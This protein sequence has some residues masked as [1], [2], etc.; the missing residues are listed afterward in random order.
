MFRLDDKAILVAGGA[1]YLGTPLCMLLRQ[2]GANVAVADRD[3]E[4]LEVA[5][6]EIKE[7]DGEGGV[8]GVHIDM[9]DEQSIL[10]S[11]DATVKRFGSLW[12]TV[13][14]TAGSTAKILEDLTAEDFDRANRINLTGDFLL[15]RASAQQMKAGGSIVLYSSM[16][17]VVAPKPANYPGDMPTNPIEYG[18]G[19]AGINQMVRYLAAHYGPA[20]IRANSICPGPFPHEGIQQNAEFMGN[21]NTSVMLGRIGRQNETA[22]P[23]AFLLSEAASYV[24]GQVL[25]VDGGWTAW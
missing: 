24:T 5:V 3:R 10:A 11:V 21:L 4:R 17:G 16:Y 14:A 22:G 1:G 25:N 2:M 18:A 15:S 12:G 9:A 20:N 8:F 23:V 19:K 7:A 13:S 6:E